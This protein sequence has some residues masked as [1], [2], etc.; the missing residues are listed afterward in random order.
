VL[1]IIT[2]ILLAAFGPQWWNSNGVG[3][4]VNSL[5]FW[6]A[7]AFLFSMTLHLWVS[8][9]KG[10]WRH[11][12]GWTWVSGAITF[13]AAIGTAFTG[14]LSMTNFSAQWIAVEGKD[15]INSI[16]V[17]AFFNL[18][19]FGQMYG[20]HIIILPLLLIALIGMHI[21][22]VRIRG[23]VRPYAVTPKEESAREAL[24]GDR[25]SKKALAAAT[26]PPPIASDQKRDYRGI[27][28]MPYDLI[29]EGLIALAV[30]FVIVVCFSGFLSS[31]DEAP[32]TLQ[33]YAQQSPVGFVTTAMSELNGTSGLAQ[34]GQPYNQGTDSVQ[35]LGSISLQQLA[36]V[37]I[38]IDTAHV[39]VLDPLAVTAQSDP[40]VAATLQ[41]FTQASAKQQGTWETNYTNA[42]AK[43]TGSNG[44]IV[45]PKADDGPIPAMMTQLLTMGTSGALDGQLLR[46]GGFYQNDFTKPLM[47]LSEDAL[48][49]KATQFNLLG[50]QWGVMNE[51]GNYPGQ[52]WLWL[53]TFWYQVPPFDTSSNADALI[54]LVM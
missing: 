24:W 51:T 13:L 41:T 23:I 22:Q 8:F 42:L 20:F 44:Q 47:F 9:F 35:Y 31:P 19:N 29:R 33:L 5:H 50:S 21:L 27:H 28:M 38:S 15:A 34:Y 32:L 54:L 6:S 37:T 25:R 30:L 11:G 7:E 10:A 3:H 12:R 26:T 17:G 18:M 52:A 1:L 36:G 49:T 53:Y 43:A 16:G 40:Q 14:Y 48:P 4:F 2:G 45:V 46:S 39:Y